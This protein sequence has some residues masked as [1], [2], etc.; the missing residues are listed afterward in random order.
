MAVLHGQNLQR[1]D[2]QAGLMSGLRR[3]SL[4]PNSWAKKADPD[5]SAVFVVRVSAVLWWVRRPPAAQLGIA[6]SSSGGFAPGPAGVA[7][8]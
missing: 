6:A 4:A 1:R 8:R 2:P 3:L 5:R 7:G